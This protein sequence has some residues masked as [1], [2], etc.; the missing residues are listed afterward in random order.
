VGNEPLLIAT[1]RWMEEHPGAI[2]GV[3]ALRLDA[4]PRGTPEL[5]RARAELEEELR[6][7][8][9]GQTRAQIRSTGHLPAYDAYYRRFDQ[10]YHVLMQIESVALKGKPIARRGPL[11]EAGFL[12][13]LATGIL[14]A[15]HD[16]A[17]VALPIVIDSA[18]SDDRY[19][20]YNGQEAATKP[21][22]MLMRDQHGI[23][24]TI[25]QGP[26]ARA[27]V[28]PETS[29]VIYCIYAPPG[30]GPEAVTDHL[31]RIEHY[32]RMADPAAT[33]L[34]MTVLEAR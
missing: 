16:L 3:L 31:S 33:Q 1:E 5:D 27:R 24:T 22:D 15:S 12:A 9:H 8:Y 29:S 19:T 13:E 26:A 2:A 4:P 10:T 32:V 23:L 14:T 30:I 11:V 21:G 7:R 6:Q 20:L 34:G 17:E 18:T 28:Q 25:I